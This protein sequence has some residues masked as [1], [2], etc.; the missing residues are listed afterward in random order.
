MVE[1]PVVV[2]VVTPVI[3]PF[4]YPLNSD[5]VPTPAIVTLDNETVTP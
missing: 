4:R 3:I 5:V 1:F 2:S